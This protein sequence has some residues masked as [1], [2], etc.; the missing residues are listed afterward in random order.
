[1]RRRPKVEKVIEVQGDLA[2]TVR[3]E[4]GEE[5]VRLRGAIL[6][7]VVLIESGHPESART[8][9]QSTLEND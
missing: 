2:P 9:L 3:M 8:L 5:I 7:A 6:E 4:Y 1:M